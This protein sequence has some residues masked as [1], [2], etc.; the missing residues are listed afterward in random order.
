MNLSFYEEQ[1]LEFKI[2]LNQYDI[3]DETADLLGNSLNTYQ[4]K[5]ALSVILDI[6]SKNINE[7]FRSTSRLSRSSIVSINKIYHHNLNEKLEIINNE[8]AENMLNLDEDISVMIKDV[9]KPCEN[10]G[11][12]LKDYQHLS[13][14]IGILNLYLAD[15]IKNKKHGVNVLFYGLPGTGKTELTKVISKI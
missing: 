3:L 14:D 12:E 2:L 5:K 4:T 10:S 9:V 7:I 13:K 6:P 8:F 11:L 1:I 15:A